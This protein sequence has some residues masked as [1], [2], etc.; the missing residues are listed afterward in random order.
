VT[1][2]VTDAPAAAFRAG[3]YDMPEAIYHGD[4]VP[5]GSL[6]S[7]GARKLLPPSCPARF[8]HDRQ[9]P[10]PPTDAMDLGTA[11]HKLV[12]GAG[13][14]IHV[15]DAEDWRLKATREERDAAR[16]AGRLPL[17]KGDY[18]QVS[19]MAAAIR[20]HPVAGAIFTPERGRAEQ[21]LF[22]Q[23]AETGVWLRVRLDWMFDRPII[24]DYKTSKSAN[25]LSFAKSVA[26][27]GYFVQDAFYRRV[28]QAVTGEYPKFVFVV[29]EKEPPYLVT[30]CELDHDSVQ[31]GHALVQHAIERYRDCTASGIWP[32]Y[33]DPGSIEL[34]TLPRWARGR[35]DHL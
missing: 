2:E 18:A 11:A 5:G 34:I 19:A 32:A 31:S 24:A 29:Q 26:D 10:P 13:V 15:I 3:I 1:A 28:Y 33:T 30:V 27:F 20:A 22:Q 12:L 8:Q 16:A 25:P 21:S 23:D 7:S 6:S 35:E 4:P 9:N 17:L 14:D